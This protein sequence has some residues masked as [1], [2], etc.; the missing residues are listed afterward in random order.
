M[1]DEEQ[2]FRG[3]LGLVKRCLKPKRI[4]SIAKATNRV[5]H[6]SAAFFRVVVELGNREILPILGSVRDEASETPAR[7]AAA[8]ALWW[9]ALSQKTRPRRLLVLVPSTWGPEPGDLLEYLNIPIRYR[10]YNLAEGS[11]EGWVPAPQSSSLDQSFV[12]HPLSHPAPALFEEVSRE[13]VATDLLYRDSCW[14]L[15]LRGL[16]L[17]W[18]TRG[19]GELEYDYHDPKRLSAAVDLHNHAR[20]VESIRRVGSPSPMHRY[21]R[22]GP[23]RWLESQMLRSY[24]LL[25][26]SLGPEIYCQVPT[27]KGGHRRVIDLLT[28]TPDGRLAVLELKSEKDMGLLFQGVGYWDRVNRHLEAGDF[29]CSGYFPGKRLCRRPPLLYLV[30]PLFEFHRCLPVFRKFLRIPGKI[31]CVGINSDWRHEVRILRHFDL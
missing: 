22:H 24:R 11:L 9:E 26:S 23:E 25:N 20:C 18:E 21:Y 17:A 2:R 8:V 29:E 30:A 3:V 4:I 1:S 14:Q 12:F 5:L 7:L 19:R 16:P 27:W 6:Q 10:T 15:S 13:L 31:H 28:A